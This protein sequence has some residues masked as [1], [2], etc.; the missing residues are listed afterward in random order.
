MFTCNIKLDL[1]IQIQRQIE[2]KIQ[3]S[4]TIMF[5]EFERCSG[6]KSKLRHLRQLNRK[7]EKTK[8]MGTWKKLRT[9]EPGKH[10]KIWKKLG[11]R[12]DNQSE[13]I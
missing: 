1:Q 12:E 8:N 11:R 13:D 2:L 5:S 9:W 6:K 10:G 7:P 4:G 3:I